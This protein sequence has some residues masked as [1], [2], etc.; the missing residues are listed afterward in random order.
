V[1]FRADSDDSGGR[2]KRRHGMASFLLALAS[3][4]FA[5]VL[6]EGGVRAFA[7]V[8]GARG[9]E[10]AAWDPLAVKVEP[11]GRFGYRQR[12]GAVY[13]YANGTRATT[14]AEGWRGPTVAIPKPSGVVRVILLGGSTTHGWGVNDNETIDAYLRADL[15]KRLPDRR[16]EVV[17]LALDGYDAYQDW[18]RWE[19]DGIRLQPDAVVINSG[20]NDVR[21]ARFQRLGDPDPRTL[22]WEADMKR[23]RETAARGHALPWTLAKHYSY[24]LRLPG[25]L[26]QRVAGP[27]RGPS[28]RD[29]VY[30]EA[31]DNFELN[32]RRVVASA[33]RLGIPVVLSTPPSV[34]TKSGGPVEM[35]PRSYWIVNAEVTQAYRDSLSTRLERI[36]RTSTTER[37]PVVHVVPEVPPGDFADDCHL[38]PAGNRAMAGELGRVLAPLLV[39]R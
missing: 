2:T 7:L 23:L 29:H 36:A 37:E 3:V 13:P 19:T 22:I 20:I 25:L 8:G 15:S 31:A 16:V 1:T 35:V 4:F 21:N 5:L 34:L 17:N 26:R 30:F 32:V 11:H 14:N 38:T 28:A 9:H 39:A 24:L 6:A 33:Q 27:V 12:P 10:I 18:Q